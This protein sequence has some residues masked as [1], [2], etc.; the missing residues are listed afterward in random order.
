[1]EKAKSVRSATVPS[2]EIIAL[3]NLGL[4]NGK[5]NLAAILLFGKSPQAI[6]SWATI[7][8]GKFVGDELY[9]KMEKEVAGNLIEQIEKSYIEVLYLIKREIE[10]KDL[11]RREVYE[12]PPEAIRELIVNA[13]AHRDYSI[14]SPIYIKIFDQKITVENPGGLPNGITVDDLKKPHKSV[15]RNPKIANVLYNLGYIEKW[16]IGTIKVVKEC[17]HNGNGEPLFSSNKMFKVEIISRYRKTMDKKEET[18]LN[19]IREKGL[20]SRREL[21]KVLKLKESS[22]RKLLEG[23][24][25]KGL[26]VKEGKGKKIRYKIALI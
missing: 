25:S 22:V 3:K 19:Y 18:A 26:I 21:E 16:G 15:L 14:R 7:K 11:V 4:F 13:V 24:Q 2:D 12:Y 8:I 10:V 1:M 6:A 5:A 23:L 9:P 20:V 17:I